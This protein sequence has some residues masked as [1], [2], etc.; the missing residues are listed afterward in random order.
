MIRVGEATQRTLYAAP[1]HDISRRRRRGRDIGPPILERVPVDRVLVVALSVA[2]ALLMSGQRVLIAGVMIAFDY[3]ACAISCL[4]AV[5][6]VV[7][8][9]ST[10]G[11]RSSVT[12]MR[13]KP[14]IDMAGE[15]GRAMEPGASSDKQAANKPI[16]PVV[17]VRRAVVGRVR[18]VPIGA[19]GRY[20]NVDGD[21]R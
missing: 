16:G 13:V 15:V 21:L 14:V 19:H 18:K 2:A 6:V 7:G 11:Q 5:E 20:S 4:V 12:V 9:I 3:V 8:L 1:L 17:A 10:R